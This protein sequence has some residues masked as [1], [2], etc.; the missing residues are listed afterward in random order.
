VKRSALR[1]PDD[2]YS[3]REA[4][5]FGFVVNKAFF[6]GQDPDPEPS[7]HEIRA[8]AALLRAKLRPPKGGS[9]SLGA[10][11]QAHADVSSNTGRSHSRSITAYAEPYLVPAPFFGLFICPL[12]FL[13]R[14]RIENIDAF[15]HEDFVARLKRAAAD[16]TAIKR[17]REERLQ[18]NGRG[19]TE[20]PRA[21]SASHHLSTADNESVVLPISA[22]SGTLGTSSSAGAGDVE[23]QMLS[24]IASHYRPSATTSSGASPH[25]QEP[26]EGSPLA[27]T[28][29]PS[30]PLASAEG[31]PPE[32]GGT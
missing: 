4:A 10:P 26:G 18:R 24:P 16:D 13:R 31:S 6:N 7:K 9:G 3:D 17:Y 21:G 1:Y 30:A 28:S 32:P 8:L 20:L 5:I 2:G 25:A 14:W 12:P 11:H 27:S 22:V 29:V 23:L 19:T 15:K